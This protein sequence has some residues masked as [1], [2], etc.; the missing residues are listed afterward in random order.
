MKARNALEGIEGNIG[1]L[2]NK[3][4]LVRMDANTK[5]SQKISNNNCP[6]CVDGNDI[7]KK[8]Q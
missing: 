1:N 2:S 5:R 3:I 6:A 8:V 4:D 7:A